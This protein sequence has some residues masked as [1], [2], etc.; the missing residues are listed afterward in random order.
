VSPE[1]DEAVSFPTTTSQPEQIADTHQTE[2][3]WKLETRRKWAKQD[4]LSILMQEYLP[5]NL[6]VVLLSTLRLPLG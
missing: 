1:W 4:F 2:P 5:H 3:D 6:R